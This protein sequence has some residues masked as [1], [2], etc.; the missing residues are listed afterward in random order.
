MF[1]GLIGGFGGCLYVS[2][3]F[4]NVIIEDIVYM[5]E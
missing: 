5:F 2:G 4:G 1:D 3:L